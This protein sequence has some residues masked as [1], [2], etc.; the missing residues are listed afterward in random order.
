MKI[1]L[2]IDVLY[3][4]SCGTLS[5]HR[6][7]H[8]IVSAWRLRRTC[9]CFSQVQLQPFSAFHLSSHTFFLDAIEKTYIP[10]SGSCSFHPLVR[11][12]YYYVGRSGGRYDG[13]PHVHATYG[14]KKCDRGYQYQYFSLFSLDAIDVP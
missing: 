2:Y 6:S 10:D 14:G 5:I 3:V 11:I 12:S 13:I 9:D 8:T 1:P 7:V 4:M